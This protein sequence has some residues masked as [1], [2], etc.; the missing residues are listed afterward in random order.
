MPNELRAWRKIDIAI[1]GRISRIEKTRSAKEELIMRKT[2]HRLGRRVSGM[3]MNGTIIAKN[4]YRMY[5][6]K[7]DCGGR[8]WCPHDE[9]KPERKEWNEH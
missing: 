5:W 2:T 4:E 1:A 7:W 3:T 9:L 6:V 8:E